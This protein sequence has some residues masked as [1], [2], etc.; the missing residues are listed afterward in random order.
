MNFL[1]DFLKG[2]IIGIGAVAPGVSG[3]TF[4]V[5]F[6]VY[7]KLTNAIANIFKDF[8]KKAI[9]LFPLGL[10]IGFGILSFSRVMQYLFQ[11]HE[12]NVKF[13]FIG[14]MLG[15]VPS[16]IKDANK[17]GFKKSYLIPCLIA[18][19]ITTIFTILQNSTINIIPGPSTG[20]LSNI[21]Y[22]I[23]IS[24]GTIIPG[25]SSS[26]ILMYIGAYET[27]LDALVSLDLMVIIP[28][29]IGF[30]LS[31][32]LFAKLINYLFSRAYG[33]TYYTVLGFVL[34]SALAIIPK[35][36][37]GSEILLGILYCVIGASLS[38][39]FSNK[40]GE[41]PLRKQNPTL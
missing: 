10:G 11:Y 17:K 13:L 36:E 37:Y 39:I 20:L 38:Y 8:L 33:F 32:L 29:G 2:I 15:T 3:G 22:G 31:I 30:G 27:L 16:V 26:F 18:F 23:I 9:D 6:G 5:M 40:I 12:T 25:V 24:F 1:S 41:N 4:A 21:F 14:L 28:V 7:S 19:G 35:A 34:G